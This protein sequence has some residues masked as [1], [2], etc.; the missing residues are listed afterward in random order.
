MDNNRKLSF[1]EQVEWL[2]DHNVN[3]KD[4]D[5]CKYYLKQKNYF[6]KLI[7]YVKRFNG[8][9][10]KIIDSF[11]KL[12]D[13]STLDMELRYCL[14]PLC[15]DIEHWIKTYILRIVTNDPN[16]D[17]YNIVNQVI[18]SDTNP[19]DF[20]RKLFSSVSYYDMN[21]EFVIQPEYD[22]F[23]HNPPIWII[24]EISS[25]G[26][27]RSFIK[28]MSKQRPGNK[29][30]LQI[31]NSIKYINKLRNSCAHNREILTEDIYSNYN[32]KIPH[33]IYTSLRNDS[34]S[35]AQ[36]YKSL[37]LKITLTLKMHKRLCS[38]EAHLHR[39]MELQEWIKRTQR[40]Q[41]FYST[42]DIFTM[43]FSDVKN[44]VD[45]YK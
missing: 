12:I 1:D 9:D 10:K 17:G 6:Y 13:I 24:L 43:F 39:I 19:E 11:E 3:I 44:I 8:D 5:R 34:F 38:N 35:K 21:Q 27:L 33:N 37:F 31:N 15:L 45:T 18:N 32:S 16:E 41:E 36:L 23:Y 30:L 2:E 7:G 42:D 4:V 20:K 28:Y 29:D 25:I 26:K 22:E 40:F 14:L